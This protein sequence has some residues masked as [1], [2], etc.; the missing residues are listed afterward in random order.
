MTKSLSERW[1][2]N[3]VFTPKRTALLRENEMVRI[4]PGVKFGWCGNMTVRKWDCTE[5]E[6]RV[7]GPQPPTL[8][9]C[10]YSI[11]VIQIQIYK[12]QTL[13]ILL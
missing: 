7:N 10:A 9:G 11:H 12:R 6:R 8:I 2:E 3:S 4:W 5:R 13:D 1:R